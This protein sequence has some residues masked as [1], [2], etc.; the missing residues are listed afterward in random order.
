MSKMPCD[1]LSFAIR[2]RCEDDILGSL[3]ERLEFC[4]T[5]LLIRGDLVLRDESSCYVDPH[6]LLWEITDVSDRCFDFVVFSEIFAY[7][8][9]LSRGLYDDEVFD[10]I[11]SDIIV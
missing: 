4:H 7:F 5:L 11:M 9:G 10:H 1:R 8:S 3:S 2:I 6:I